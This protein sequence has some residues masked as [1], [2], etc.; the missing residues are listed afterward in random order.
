M[1][2]PILLAL[3]GTAPALIWSWFHLIEPGGV[4]GQVDETDAMGGIAQ[5]INGDV[6]LVLGRF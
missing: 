5:D 6:E 4:R 2:R 3:C 1:I